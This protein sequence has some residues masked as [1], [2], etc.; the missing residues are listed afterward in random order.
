[1]YRSARNKYIFFLPLNNLK[2]SFMI[3]YKYTDREITAIMQFTGFTRQESIDYFNDLL[4]RDNK[5]IVSQEQESKVLDQVAASFN[6]SQ[7]I[8]S[9]N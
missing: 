5:M 8:F 1:V 2:F 4:K 7:L 9:T 6:S 3:H